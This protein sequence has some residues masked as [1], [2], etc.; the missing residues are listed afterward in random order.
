MSELCIPFSLLKQKFST[1]T[2]SGFKP[3]S[4]T[5]IARSSFAI[6]VSTNR[7]DSLEQDLLFKSINLPL[8]EREASW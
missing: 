1:V 3:F 4:V 7:G 5:E 2:R 6:K 8:V